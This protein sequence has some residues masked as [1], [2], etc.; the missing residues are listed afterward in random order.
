MIYS[1]TFTQLAYEPLITPL[2][3]QVRKIRE[4]GNT[5]W[6]IVDG[7]EVVSEM[8]TEAFELMTGRKAPR[9]LMRRICNEHWEKT[10]APFQ[11]QR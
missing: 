7:L 9:R 4:D 2:V 5:S 3:D 1:L 6:V 11:A 8:A 10:S